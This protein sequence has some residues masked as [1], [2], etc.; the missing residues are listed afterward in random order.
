[1]YTPFYISCNNQLEEIGITATKEFQLETAM[2]I[3]VNNMFVILLKLIS[4]LSQFV[5]PKKYY[6]RYI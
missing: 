2:V 5:K 6:M 3:F 4:R 1:M